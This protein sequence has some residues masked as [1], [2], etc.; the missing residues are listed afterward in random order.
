[1]E[2]LVHWVDALPPYTLLKWL[3][4][5][6]ISVA[7]IVMMGIEQ[8]RMQRY[9]Q[10]LAT[11]ASREDVAAM[12]YA[13]S[14][15]T[16]SSRN[17][18][19]FSLSFLIITLSVV[20]YDVKQHFSHVVPASTAEA[21]QAACPAAEQPLAP[22]PTVTD[23]PPTNAEEEANAQNLDRLKRSYEQ[24]Y[25]NFYILHRCQQADVSDMALLNSAFLVDLVG[26]K[27]S[28]SFPLDV[29]A[30]A[31]STFDELY[32]NYDCNNPNIP[33]MK[34]GHIVYIQGVKES[35]KAHFSL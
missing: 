19:L 17:K 25:V 5:F 6:G 35:L 33:T 24:A 27:A 2:H 1:M 8:K 31:K 18:L 10:R 32:K 28:S 11:H 26:L 30:T 16:L 4:L 9:Y 29:R 12:E 7:V 13:L 22:L 20:F 21:Q 23:L 14:L 34:Q 3:L 15:L